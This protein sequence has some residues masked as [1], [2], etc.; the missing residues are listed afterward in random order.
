MKTN[1]RYRCSVDFPELN[2]V[3]DIILYGAGKGGDKKQYMFTNLKGEVETKTFRQV[4]HDFTGL[5]QLLYKRGLREKKVAILS[6]NSYYWIAAFYAV[7]TGRMT[8]VPL[9]AKL[10]DAELTEIMVR[11]GCDGIIYSD[12]FKSSIEL[13]KKTEGIQLTEYLRLDDFDNLVAEGHKDLESGVK[14]YLSDKVN[15]DDL[16]FIVYTSG[17][18]G[19]SKGVM[20]THRNVASDGTEI[21]RAMSGSHAIAFLPFNHTLSWASALLA[22]PLFAEWGYLCKSVRDLPK[23]LVSYSPQNFTAVPL[24]VETIYKKIWHTAKKQGK[25]QKLQTGIKLSR[26]LMKHGIDIRRKLF[27]EVIDNLGGDLELVICGGAYLDEMYERGLY[28][29]GLQVIV[30]YGV[31]E[32][33]P[34]ITCNRLDNFKFGSVGKPL[35]CNEV[36]IHDPDEN[37][38]GEIYVRGSNVMRGY[39]DDP[40]ATAEAFD[41]GWYRTGDFGYFD[42]EGFLY[43]KGRKKNLIV[44]SNGKNVSPEEL[45]DQFSTVDYVKEVMVYADADTIVGEFYLDSNEP[46]AEEKLRAYVLECNRKKPVFKR[47]SKIVLRDTEFPKTTTLKIKRGKQ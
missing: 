18:T 46:D 2:T 5:G 12:D 7:S 34:I 25:E 14:F 23:D 37:G 9:D 26:A 29:L 17:T 33:S 27:K 45:E 19:K 43:Y 8:A 24:A 1:V 4:Y 47:I 22:S 16:G 30:G 28:D 10:S 40:E 41:N 21:C 13:M 6:E 20:L 42:D 11:S 44:L 32:C 3:K 35:P 15:P 38:V 36:I 39:F 31:T